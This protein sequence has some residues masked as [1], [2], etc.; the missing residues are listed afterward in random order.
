M[1][2]LC[3]HV[4]CCAVR[5]WLRLLRAAQYCGRTRAD[6]RMWFAGDGGR[7]KRF[8]TCQCVRLAH[9]DMPSLRVVRQLSSL[10]LGQNIISQF[11]LSIDI[12]PA[13]NVLIAVFTGLASVLNNLY[14]PDTTFHDFVSCRRAIINFSDAASA[15]YACVGC[16][17]AALL[18][19]REEVSKLAAGPYVNLIGQQSSTSKESVMLIDRPGTTSCLHRSG[20]Y[21]IQAF[22]LIYDERFIEFGIEPHDEYD[23]NN[24]ADRDFV[25]YNVRAYTIEP[26]KILLGSAYNIRDNIYS[27]KYATVGMGAREYGRLTWL[28]KPVIVHARSTPCTPVHLIG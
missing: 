28:E 9:S 21:F 2:P 18:E 22:S 19:F 27:S 6:C 10:Q 17:T 11:T 12:R 15:K 8:Y 25:K 24:T 20:F 7:W 16:Q 13:L 4:L 1:S 5:A 3:S 23:D 26:C 14:W